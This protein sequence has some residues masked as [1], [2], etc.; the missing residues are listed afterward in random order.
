MEAIKTAAKLMGGSQE[1]MAEALSVSQ[2]TISEWLR[3]ERPVPVRFCARIE[4]ATDRAVR[5]WDLRPNDWHEIWPDL[6]K[7]PEAPEPPAPTPVTAEAA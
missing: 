6:L 1:A 2:P 3:D 4:T 5:R 7:D